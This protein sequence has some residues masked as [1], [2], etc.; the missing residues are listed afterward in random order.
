MPAE[1]APL[2]SARVSLWRR[3]V[4]FAIDF[5]LVSLLSAS[6]GFGVAAQATVF[7][8]GWLALRV[9]VV[10]RNQGQSLGRWAFDMRVM[11]AIRGGTPDLLTLTKREGML[12]VEG[13]LFFVGLTYFSPQN[14][15]V[16]LLFLPLLVDCGLAYADPDQ[17]QTLHD[18]IAKTRIVRTRRGYSLDSKI[19][20]LVADVGRRMKK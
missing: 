2:A 7:C 17:Q 11:N 5:G 3:V 4:A 6:L 20:N 14:A 9:F 10:D 18:Q 16:L 12:A 1:L 13:F 15:W 19:K 8:L